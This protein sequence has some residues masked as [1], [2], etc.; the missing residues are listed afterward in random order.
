MQLEIHDCIYFA[1]CPKN[2]FRT[3]RRREAD[4]IFKS[5]FKIF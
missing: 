3:A 1:Y 5:D 4:V 2:T